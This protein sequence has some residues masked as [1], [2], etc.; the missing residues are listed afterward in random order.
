MPPSQNAKAGAVLGGREASRRMIL[1]QNIGLDWK[2][3]LFLQII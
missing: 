1:K 3:L 2:E